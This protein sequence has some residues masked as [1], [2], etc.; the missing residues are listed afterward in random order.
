MSIKDVECLSEKGGISM[1]EQS[2]GPIFELLLTLNPGKSVGRVF[3]NGKSES[4][5]AFASFDPA[6][7]LA[8]FVKNNGDILVVDYRRIDALKFH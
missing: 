5:E 8:T 7:G 4:V 6:T 3:I 2:G 1:S